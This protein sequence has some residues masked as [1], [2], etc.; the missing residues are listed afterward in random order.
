MAGPPIAETLTALIGDRAYLALVE[1]YGGTRLYVPRSAGLSDLPGQIGEAAAGKLASAYGGE[2]IKV[3]LD[4][5]RRASHYRNNRLSNAEIARR[6]GI[7][8][9][10]V[11]RLFKRVRKAADDD[12]LSLL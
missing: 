6:L 9:S 2:Y 12:Q 7:T 3:P 5:E 8:E 1:H 4:R 10:G 11:E